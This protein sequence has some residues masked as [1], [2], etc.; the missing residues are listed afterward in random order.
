MIGDD[1]EADILGARKHL[2]ALTL[3]KNHHGVKVK[4]GKDAPDVVFDNFKEIVTLLS[5]C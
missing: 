4:K 3:Q 5:Q 1:T 2:G